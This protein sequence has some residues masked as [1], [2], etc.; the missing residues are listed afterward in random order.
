MTGKLTLEMRPVAV[1]T[2][3]ESALDAVRPTAQAKAIDLEVSV[4]N[5]S[6]VVLGD[7][8]RLQQ[9][10]WNLL[11]NAIKFTSS[12]GR[13]DVQVRGEGGEVVLTVSDTGIG[14]DREFLPYVFDRFRQADS[15]T[16]RSHGGLGLG[17]AIVR[18]L[19]ELHGGRVGVE[20]E[21]RGGGASFI[22]RL[23]ALTA[24][25]A[26]VAVASAV[27][28]HAIAASALAGLRVLVV[29][30]QADARDLI[31]ASLEQYG[32]TVTKAAS[33]R[34]ACEIIDVE[35]PNVL[36]GDIGMP[37]EDGYSLI[38]RVR[39]RPARDGGQIPA[40]ALTAYA[41][42]EDRARALDAGF[43]VHLAKPINDVDLVEA[44]ASLSGRP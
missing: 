41:R 39:A 20:S 5:P 34:E 30:D 24:A 18:H 36:I 9:V 31:A 6:L 25:P 26:S 21:G 10:V 44:V 1:A 15:S 38:R 17:L 22:L 4:G 32:A 35:P 16:T 3:I 43:Q 19:A 13:V 29:D 42:R 28:V 2:V 37:E 27:G 7:H 14:I 8:G 33:A 11:S 40:I 23:P 12:G